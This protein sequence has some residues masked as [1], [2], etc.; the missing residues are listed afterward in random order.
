LEI[1]VEISGENL[2]QAVLEAPIHG[3]F[4]ALK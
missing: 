4:A 1:K 2:A 3:N